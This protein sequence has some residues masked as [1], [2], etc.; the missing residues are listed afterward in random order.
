M[1]FARQALRVGVLALALGGL[2]VALWSA[3]EPTSE[4]DWDRVARPFAAACILFAA[5]PLVQAS[6][7][8]LLLRS[9][10]GDPS[11]RDG[12]NVWTR[13]F[14]LRYA[15]TGAL[16]YVYRVRSADRL[17]AGSRTMIW[18][19]SAYEQLVAVA[20]GSAVSLVAFAVAGSPV[21]WP[22][23]VAGAAALAVIVL[24]RPASVGG[25]L[26]RLARRRGFDL[27]PPLRARRLGALVLLSAAAWVPTGMAGWILFSALAEDEIS[28][29]WFLGAYAFAWLAGFLVPIAPGGLGVREAVLAGF[30]AAPL[31]PGAA[32]AVAVAI[33]LAN[34]FGELVAVSV[35]E[36]AGFEPRR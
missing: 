28:F 34:T 13:A 23:A 32:A 4:L 25:A 12:V 26:A 15:P 6:V 19:A 36:L 27:P 7:F 16:G 3:R 14:L 1:V 24:L 29:S 20:A 5:A 2:A 22:I 8:V 9:L 17:R 35:S 33:R 18:A 11:A 30:L 21:P 10:G 31:T